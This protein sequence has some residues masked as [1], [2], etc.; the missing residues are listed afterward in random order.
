MA[1]ARRQSVGEIADALRRARSAGGS[2]DLA[3]ATAE[4]GTGERANEVSLALSR[5]Q[6]VR[7][8]DVPVR[9]SPEFP[10]TADPGAATRDSAA[11]FG[12]DPRDGAGVAPADRTTEVLEPASES[13]LRAESGALLE[14]CRK[15]A[16]R[17]RSELKRR[18]GVSVALVS[19][20]N[21]EGKTTAACNLGLALATLSSG[22]DVA[23]VDL[24]LRRPSVA[25]AL[26]LHPEVGIDHVLAGGATLEDIRVSVERP[27]LDIF[28]A[29]RVRR[30]THELLVLPSLSEILRELALRYEFV[31]VDTPPALM[32]PD[33]GIILGHVSACV[34]VA[35]AGRTRARHSRH[36]IKLLEQYVVLGQ[37]LNEGRLPRYEYSVYSYAGHEKPT[38]AGAT[39][40]QGKR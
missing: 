27:Q 35:R 26:G 15:L 17:V 33:A 23:L 37:I 32:V 20:V 28:P 30:G 6:R 16:L 22:R 8:S 36:L 31:I 40:E 7:E 24:D 39:A 1:P 25:T 9:R 4:A 18:G 3:D 38:E 19:A 11:A 2:E 5:A 29:T 14:I 21:G 10:P 13:I 34:P 12:S